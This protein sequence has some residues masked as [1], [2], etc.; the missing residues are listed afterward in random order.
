MINVKLNPFC[1]Q[2]IAEVEMSRANV[3]AVL[4]AIY[5]SKKIAECDSPTLRY[6]KTAAQATTGQ[7]PTAVSKKSTFTRVLRTMRFILSLLGVTELCLIA[8][9][10][11]SL[12]MRSILR[13]KLLNLSTAVEN[14]VLTSRKS[15]FWDTIRTF[16]M[17]MIPTSACFAAFNYLLSELAIH[18]RRST[19][20]RLLSKFTTGRVYYQVVNAAQLQ[21]ITAN[22]SSA[23]QLNIDSY[24]NPD[25]ILTNDIEHFSYAL[26][27][28]FS[29]MMRP[30]VDILVNAQ[31]LY[32]TGGAFIPAVMGI[33]LVVTSNL[34][35]Y[36][37]SPVADFTDGEQR[38]EGEYRSLIARIATSAEEIAALEGG[39]N[40]EANV[41][42]SLHPLLQYS[43]RFAQFRCN[44]S[45]I[46]SVV[47]RYWLMILGW[48]IVGM[49]FFEKQSN[50]PA[51]GE[52]VFKDYQNMSKTMLAL[53]NAV[54]ELIMS[55]R[56]VVKVFA[57]GEKLA[58]FEDA[59][60]A[61][62]QQSEMPQPTGSV[63]A[64]SAVGSVSCVVGNAIQGES[65]AA[66]LEMDS[67]RG[68]NVP[69]AEAPELQCAE[70]V[71]EGL[72]QTSLAFENVSIVPP[73]H[74][75]A[76]YSSL[77]IVFRRYFQTCYLVCT[78]CKI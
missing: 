47:A 69:P 74:G 61:L 38:L 52:T 1:R 27:G 4:L 42:K 44:M 62:I 20:T 70:S 3:G 48:R 18:V 11:A 71:L 19:T 12:I 13:L 7:Q 72:N 60:D 78:A 41:L 63:R 8:S 6:G 58:E 65:A 5:A 45:F 30:I 56:D 76:L 2:L 37:R 51:Q 33:Y 32:V 55:G 22:N 67:A 53:S 40:E 10:A 15:S 9:I 25:Q 64:N 35:N 49:H 23:E 31:R 68:A 14:S 21:S 46:D 34:L 43:R 54:G 59:L 50:D 24:P 36:I 28:L 77:N 73:N 16:S 66:G 29:H 75:D 39:K 26:S 57:Y 17:Y